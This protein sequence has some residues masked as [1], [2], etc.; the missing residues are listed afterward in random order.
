MYLKVGTDSKTNFD[1]GRKNIKHIYRLYRS[2]FG[3]VII[4]PEAA[5]SLKFSLFCFCFFQEVR[6]GNR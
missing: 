4:L 5:I 3:S 2:D 6:K 1:S